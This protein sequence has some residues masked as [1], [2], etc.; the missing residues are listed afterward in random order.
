MPDCRDF[1][2]SGSVDHTYVE[3][4]KGGYVGRCGV[5][6]PGC[7]G[8]GFGSNSLGGSIDSDS[9]YLMSTCLLPCSSGGG[10]GRGGSPP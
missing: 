2:V 6:T 4:F 5:V 9:D 3:E 7:L 10:G 8:G 1:P